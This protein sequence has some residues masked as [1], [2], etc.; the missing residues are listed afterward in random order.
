MK[1]IFIA[2]LALGIIFV[3]TLLSTRDYFDTDLILQRIEKQSGF[4]IEL[5][6]KN[7]LKLYPSI[8]FNNPNVT[9]KQ[10]NN[11]L[12]IK[13][14]ILNI[15]KSYW[16]TS[17][18]HINISSY[19]TNYEGMEI[20]DLLLKAKYANNVVNIENISGKIVE[21]NLILNGKLDLDGTQAFFLNGEFDN[22][23]L[24][25]LLRQSQVAAWERVEIKLS[26]PSFTISGE[27][28]G[29]NNLAA[30][31]SGSITIQ[32]SFYLI[33]SEEER[34]GAALLSLLTEKIPSVEPMSQ[35]ID[36]ILSNYSDIPSS[37]NGIL[38]IQDGFIKSDKILI[39]NKMAESSVK[40]SYDFLN[41][42]IDGTILFYDQEEVFLKLALQG[43]INN[44]EILIGGKVF[45][46]KEDEP[47][48]DIKLLFEQGINSLVEKL[49]RSND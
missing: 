12:E 34:F 46:T 43:K 18:Y 31:I 36:F 49:I 33:S 23:S 30:S 19:A 16:P 7:K 24:N 38:T 26:S 22:I 13:S 47:L 14:A 35:A 3:L 25:T 15:N 29:K 9:I 42:I 17:P 39:I 44:P 32:G 1:K 27:G 48:K 21:G 20:R 41:D 8:T 40:G 4:K 28:K 11:S 2:I 45:T 10:N 37:I 5:N 6:G